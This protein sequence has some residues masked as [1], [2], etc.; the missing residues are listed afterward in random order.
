M[1]S[2]ITT[3]AGAGDSQLAALTGSNAAGAYVPLG[4]TMR[5]QVAVG[6]LSL[7]SW[8]SCKGLKVD[9][10]PEQIDEA[11]NPYYRPV[12]F[13][14]A[15]YPKITLE[16]AMNSRD[17]PVLQQWLRSQLEQWLVQPP[18]A[19]AETVAGERAL[20]KYGGSTVAITLFDSSNAIVSS[21]NL[22]GVYP[23]S[24]TGP[25]MTAEGTGAVA[26]ETLELVHEGFL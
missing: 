4:L 1:T 2:F 5:F 21:W 8:N 7:G 18:K 6:Q 9:F 16:R 22:R 15:S 23:A 12:L 14:R 11:G 20:S 13:G 24:W 26:K 25:S 10:Q 3:F 19:A 17:S